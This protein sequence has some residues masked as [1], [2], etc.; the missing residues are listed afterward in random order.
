[1]CCFGLGETNSGTI[2]SGQDKSAVNKF[3][4]ISNIFFSLSIVFPN[5]QFSKSQLQKYVLAAALGPQHVLAAALGPIAHHSLSARPPLQP[6][7]PQRA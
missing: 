1:M 6:A 3:R 5:E 7:A 4:K 2:I